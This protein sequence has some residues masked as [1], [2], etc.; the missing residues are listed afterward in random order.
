[1]A[2]S[3]WFQ[4]GGIQA[5]QLPEITAFFVLVADF[6]LD[7]YDCDSSFLSSRLSSILLCF[8]DVGKKRELQKE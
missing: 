4:R 5:I 3:K 1:M 8:S 6:I 7:L 2:A